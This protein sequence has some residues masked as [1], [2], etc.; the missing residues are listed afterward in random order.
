MALTAGLLD[1]WALGLPGPAV[2][3]R[4]KISTGDLMRQYQD[5]AAHKLFTG[6]PVQDAFAAFTDT[7]DGTAVHIDMGLGKTIIGLTAIADWFTFGIISRPVLLIAPIKV[8]ET[9]WRQEARDWTHTRHLTFELVRGNERQR[10][11]A[12]SRPAHVYLINREQLQWLAKYLRND[13]SRFDALL[14]DDT[15]FRDHKTKSFRVLCNYGTQV[16]IKDAAG[17]ALRY[18]DGSPVIVPPHRF[19]RCGYLTG[20]PSPNG[21]L[22]LWG[23]FYLMDHGRRLHARFDTYQGRFFHRTQEVADHVFKYAVNE[24]EDEVRPE[25]QARDGAPERIHEL[26]ADITVELNAEDYGV[27]PQKVEHK[28]FVELPG[29]LRPQYDMLEREA[30]LE[31]QRDVVMAQN[32]GAKSLMCWQFANGAVYSQDE[33]GNKIWTELHTGKLDKLVELIDT[34]NANVIVPYYFKHDFERLKARFHKEGMAF[35]TLNKNAERVID[36]WN[37]G[38]IPILLL[39]PQSAGH[40]L[41]LQFGGHNIIWFTMLWSLERYLQTIARLARSGQREVVGI[42]HIL[43]RGTIDEL[44]F[45]NLGAKGDDQQRFRVAL[46]QYQ[47]ERGLGLYNPLQGLV[48]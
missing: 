29:A 7:R 14:I 11:F 30:V 40:G 41:N 2:V 21:M 34:L 32:G 26:I 18:S 4:R 6:T 27:L 20:T 12:L 39:H 28:H 44:M 24:G 25:W 17:K 9:V 46:R 5:R 42:H 15:P 23:P 37:K 38:A 33:M 19:K 10:A 48:I 22:N 35:A 3:E 36:Q 13:W 8:C 31:L 16:A 1:L 47:Q 45:A 43:T